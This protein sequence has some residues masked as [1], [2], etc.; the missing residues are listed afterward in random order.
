MRPQLTIS[1]LA[2]KQIHAVRKCLDSLVP[3]LM[4]VP[5]ELIVVDTSENNC[6]RELALQYTPY[7][8]PFHWCDDFSKARNAGLRMAQ[9]EWFLYLDDDEW[10]EDPKE[11][12]AF[13]TNAEYL[14]YNSA[15]YIVRN[16]TDWMGL[17][18][19]DAHLNRMIRRTSETRFVNPIHEFLKPFREPTKMFSAYVHHYG[20]VG[21]VLDS[22]S[23]RNIPLL[24]KEL[25]HALTVHNC[26]QLSQE[27]MSANEFAKAE[28]YALKCLELKEPNHD[29]EKSWCIAYLPYMIRSQEEYKR[30]WETGKE[31][32]RHPKCTEI[33]ALRIY[34][35]L[36]EVCKSLKNHEKDIIIYAKAYHQSLTQLDARPEQWFKQTIGGLGEQKSKSVKDAIYLLGF[37]AAIDI[38]DSNSAVFFLQCFSWENGESEK[39]YPS[40]C[41]I[42]RDRKKEDFLLGLFQQL[43]ISD[44][45]VW[46]MKSRSAWKDGNA[47]QLE[48]Y[49]RLAVESDQILV[50][51][52]AAL[53]AFQSQGEIS[54]ELVMLTTNISQWEKISTYL[55]GN[56]EITQLPHWINL[57]KSYLINFPVQSLSLLITF[58][59][60]LLIEGVLEIEDEDLFQEIKQYCQWVKEYTTSVY[61]EQLLSCAPSSFMPP[62]Y[63]FAVQMEQVFQNLENCDYPKVLQQ[64]HEVIN[65]YKP[66]CGV[67][68]RMLSMIADEINQPALTNSEFLALAGQV[69]QT[70]QYLIQEGRYEESL[71]LV[72]QLSS[73]LP[74][75]LE[76]VRLRQELW[77]HMGE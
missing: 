21:N 50:F 1:L 15:C 54:L 60:K 11:I 28:I 77:S 20:Y 72:Q 42:L 43:D 25:E 51:M 71:P 13:F 52:E 76:V 38:E 23:D 36:I 56:V 48:K 59:E 70:V 19:T 27:Y 18:Y 5:S 32:L 26:L 65:A 31:M 9:G 6:I 67:I 74:R 10:F 7:V 3:I 58:Q 66:L 53:L 4:Q 57:S 49:F 41:N 29:R 63:R 8:I 37:K 62:N 12:I 61:S 46:I 68:R 45:F 40:F 75:D 22:K 16:Y 30:A 35:D 47:E 64:L 17:D 14:N 24:E 2:S 73:L 33:A 34:V 39:L 55:A 44:P 69:K